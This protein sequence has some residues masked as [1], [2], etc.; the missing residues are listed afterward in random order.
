[1]G[2]EKGLL[3]NRLFPEGPFKS[4]DDGEGLLFRSGNETPNTTEY[5]GSLFAAKRPG[6]LLLHLH[7]P[8]I[9]FRLVVIEGYARVA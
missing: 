5:L 3:Q 7:H 8:Y 4:I 2:S 9:S 6:N 1:M